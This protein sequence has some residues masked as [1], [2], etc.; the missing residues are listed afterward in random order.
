MITIYNF[1]FINSSDQKS[2]I[3][4]TIL[5]FLPEWFGIESAIT[6]YTEKVSSMPFWAA[7]DDELPIGFIALKIHNNYTCE[8]YVMGIL[9]E[10]HRQGIG[11]KLT[12]WCE[13]FAM[14]QGYE[15]LTVK[16]LDS[17]AES[18][19]YEKTREFYAAV[20]FR[21]LE[22]FPLLWDEENPCLFMGK[23]LKKD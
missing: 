15:Y 22:V 16:T 13:A 2:D 10:Y 4:S 5:H 9:K 20:G 12:E 21:P 23:Y 7:F 8:I 14:E 17:S 1:E 3:C 11:K 6:D 18:G 19:D